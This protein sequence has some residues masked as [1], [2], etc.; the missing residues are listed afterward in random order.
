LLGI[1]RMQRRVDLYRRTKE[2]VASDANRTDVQHDAIEVE[3]NALAELDVAAVV[4]KERRLHPYGVAARA[5][6]V[7]QDASARFLFR[8]ARGIQC[9]TQV[10]CP[11]SRCRELG[12]RR[13]VQ[14][15]SQHLVAFARHG[16]KSLGS[17]SKETTRTILPEC[18]HWDFLAGAFC[19]P[20][21]M[22]S[23]P[24]AGNPLIGIHRAASANSSNQAVI[25]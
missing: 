11:L 4:A 6:Q 14:I 8:F 9:L 25:G 20:Q 2:R 23:N 7:A 10:S 19:K 17:S 22:G 5:E 16:R 13:I 1:E 24:T 3:E 18:R 12:I 21:V 15:A